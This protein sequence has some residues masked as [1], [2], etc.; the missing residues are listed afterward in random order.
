[1]VSDQSTVDFIVEQMSH[2]GESRA[3]KMFG[4]YGVYFDE[5]FVGV[6]CSDQLYLK[7]TEPGRR[8][9]PEAEEAPP[10]D[11]ARPY[12]SIPAE[13]I[14]DAERLREVTRATA[15]ALPAPKPK[16]SKRK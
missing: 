13:V 3:R 10:Y 5:K 14:E 2:S 9:L 4:E 7:I 6:I 16:R 8:L 15:E 12:L 11:G 1:M